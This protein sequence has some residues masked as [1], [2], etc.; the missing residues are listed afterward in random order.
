MH[1]ELCEYRVQA[2]RLGARGFLE[3]KECLKVK[4]EPNTSNIKNQPGFKEVGVQVR[5]RHLR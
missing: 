4:S 2:G 3:H 5:E 1:R